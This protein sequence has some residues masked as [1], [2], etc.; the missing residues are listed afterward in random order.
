M[1]V[2]TYLSSPSNLLELPSTCLAHLVQHVASGSGG[3]ASAAALS[4]TC[5]SFY[6]L[7][8]SS[9]VTYRN[10]HLDTPL[11]SSLEHPFWPWLAKRRSRVDGLTAEVRLT[12]G[13]PEHEP[14]QLQMMFGIPGPHLT[15]RCDGEISTPDDPFMVQVLR[16]HGALIEHLVFVA[17]IGY[18]DGLALQGFCEAAAPCRS[19]DLTVKRADGR[20][21]TSA[22]APVAGFLV[23]LDLT[24]IL[25]CQSESV[26]SLSLLSQLTSLSLD[27]CEFE[28]EEPWMH[29]AE[30]TNLKQLSLQ[31]AASGD[32]STLSVLTGLSSLS[33]MSSYPLIGDWLV[34]PWT[35]SSLQP[36]STMQEL[37]ELV[38]SDIACSATSLHGLVELSSLE[39]LRLK[40]PLM[41]KTLKGVS[42][43]LT[44]LTV[45]SATRLE[46]LAGIEHLQG[47][48]DLSL[49][50]CG[51]A[52]LYPI[53]ALES[54]RNLTIGGTFGGSL[55]SLTVLEGNLCTSLHSLNLRCC[56]EL[57]HLS[58]IERFTSLQQLEIFFCEDLMS[59]EPVGQ[60]VGGLRYLHVD[61][62]R[63]L[64]GGGGPRAAPH[65]AH[66]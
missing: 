54:L 10:L 4:G 43:G 52:P 20:I 49:R 50:D 56:N 53:V 58:G 14:E 61:E 36:L 5:K 2:Q 32:P 64:Q 55:T 35:F 34:D 21:P 18:V 63:C 33:L 40:F 17:S 22:L 11:I 7:S 29:L 38:L 60:L 62:C 47:L 9:A 42:R 6:A 66:S 39:T 28:A 3:L 12:V 57:S 13:I 31:V 23:R 26:S 1:S 8:E 44:S 24:S 27:G 15:L 30:M 46:S 48:H 41:L 45:Y 19:L 25:H 37:K 16:P 65:S 51:V 59:L